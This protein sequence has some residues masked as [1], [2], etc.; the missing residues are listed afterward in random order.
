MSELQ[1]LTAIKPSL[2]EKVFVGIGRAVENRYEKHRQRIVDNIIIP[3]LVGKPREIQDKLM[4]RLE[5]A[6]KAAAV[7]A[8]TAEIV[9]GVIAVVGTEIFFQKGIGKSG[10]VAPS[11]LAADQEWFHRVDWDA[12]VKV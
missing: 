1:S 5:L 10:I 6:A 3:H 2:P 7:T 4:P 12:A 11:F 8:T 9:G